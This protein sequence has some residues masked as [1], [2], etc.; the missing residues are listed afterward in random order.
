M[1]D[2]L[3]ELNRIKPVFVELGLQTIHEKTAEYIRRGYTLDVYDTALKK[4]KKN[5]DKYCYTYYFGTSE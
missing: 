1:I 3:K 2:L 5:R 4:L